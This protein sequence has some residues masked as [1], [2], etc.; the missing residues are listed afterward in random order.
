MD[1]TTSRAFDR[2]FLEQFQGYPGVFGD[3]DGYRSDL[4]DFIDI[5][6][7]RRSAFFSPAHRRVRIVVGRKGSGKTFYLKKLQADASW[8][9]E[10]SLGSELV[11][12]AEQ[13]QLLSTRHVFSVSTWYSNAILTEVWQ[14]AWGRAI[15][16]SLSSQILFNPDFRQ[17]I[18]QGTRQTLRR[19]FGALF[20]EYLELDERTPFTTLRTLILAAGDSDPVECAARFSRILDDPLWDDL[21]SRLARLII[22]FPPVF[23]FIDAID[24]EFSH[25][26]MYWMRCQKGLF[27][28]VM[29]I[30]RHSRLGSKLHIVIAIREIVLHS[31]FRSE[32]APRYIGDP[33]IRVLEWG[34]DAARSFIDRKVQSLSREHWRGSK[35]PNK[36]PDWLGFDQVTNRH[37]QK[38]DVYQYLLRHTQCL[39]REMVMFG[40]LLGRELDEANRQGRGFNE[41]DF[42]QV[43]NVLA[44]VSGLFQLE[45]AANQARSDEIPG[46]AFQ[47]DFLESYTSVQEYADQRAQELIDLIA[48]FRLLR[49]THADFLEL[50]DLGRR[51]IGAPDLGSVLWQA[52][53]LGYVDEEGRDVFFSL[54]RVGRF[55]IPSSAAEYVFHPSMR[56]VAGLAPSGR[57]VLW[58]RLS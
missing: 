54:D 17:Y 42:H 6:E 44:R 18:D 15:I 56:E 16:L 32:H 4:S 58:R 40:N 38:E 35:R 24:E 33:H 43:V 2:S 50:Q 49:I 30:L 31:V 52:G 55:V 37:R 14:Q 36:L 20:Q 57:P 3:P 26:P 5:S 51:S 41:A 7:L 1:S 27:Y 39:P 22:D 53:I 28:E 11:V 10:S 45:M 19:D 34:F 8:E 21:E 25:A 12:D 13:T 48:L 29:R 9:Y 46:E 47:H 23:M